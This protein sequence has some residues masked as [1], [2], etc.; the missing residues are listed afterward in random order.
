[1]AERYS[2]PKA[3]RIGSIMSPSNSDSLAGPH[4]RAINLTADQF[5]AFFQVV[6]QLRS[7]PQ[8]RLVNLGIESA[9][10]D[11]LLGLIG[12]LN[13]SLEGYSRV[14]IEV[15]V[16]DSALHPESSTHLVERIEGNPPSDT[17][18]GELPWRI[19]ARLQPLVEMVVSSLGPRE[20]FLRTGYT[21]EE[22]R[23]ASE[24]LYFT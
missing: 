12:S 10:L 21:F 20:L 5:E 14:R 24:R 23:E 15:S 17:L 1:M 2:L 3:E 4:V 11:R 16:A 9:D 19:A 8:S 18:R 22:I 6:H 7:L 13:G